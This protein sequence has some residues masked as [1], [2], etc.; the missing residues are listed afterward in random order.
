MVVIDASDSSAPTPESSELAFSGRLIDLRVDTLCT[1]DDHR[2][3][4]EIVVHPG[5]VGV[6]PLT[7]D[8][9]VVLVRQYRHATGTELLEIPAGLIDGD[10]LPET[11]A[12]REL[13]EETGCHVE[14]LHPIGTFWLSPGYSTEQCYLFF[15]PECRCPDFGTTREPGVELV[16]IAMSTLADLLA[17]NRPLV[18]DA[19]T[20]IALQWLLLQRTT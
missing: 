4:R 20:M 15:A 10:E 14:R 5:S 9:R 1:G 11:A 16:V 3:Q 7:I 12:R 8:D 2:S 18:A 6:L 17:S 13:Q 19:K